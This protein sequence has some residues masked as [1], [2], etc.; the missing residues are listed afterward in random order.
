MGE[1]LLKIWPVAAAVL[2]AVALGS[3]GL[4][5]AG[6]AAAAIQ[7]QDGEVMALREAAAT[8]RADHAA[9]Q[10]QLVRIERVLER[11]EQRPTQRP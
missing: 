4:F 5:R 1:A 2:A 7:R 11:L 9:I 10:A 3:V 6:D 8:N